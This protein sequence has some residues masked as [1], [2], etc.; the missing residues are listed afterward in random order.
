MRAEGLAG[1]FL[2]S[3]LQVDNDGRRRIACL[4][5]LWIL[6]PKVPIVQQGDMVQAGA[7]A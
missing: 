5:F 6:R 3:H 2:D 1:C 4:F 7:H